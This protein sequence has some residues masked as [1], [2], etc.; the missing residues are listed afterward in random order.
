[1][2]RTYA[3]LDV[4]S[5]KRPSE[6][7]NLRGSERDEFVGRMCHELLSPNSH[8]DVDLGILDVDRAPDLGD[9]VSDEPDETNYH[10]CQ[11]CVLYVLRLRYFDL[12]IKCTDHQF[13]S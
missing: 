6:L 10:R 7:R 5:E 11:G 9:E 12:E 4:V 8:V 13:D 1:M 3:V 2:S